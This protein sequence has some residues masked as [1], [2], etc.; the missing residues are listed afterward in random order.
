MDKLNR[1]TLYFLN[2]QLERAS[3]I[4]AILLDTKLNPDIEQLNQNTYLK[5]VDA[6]YIVQ[7]V[8]SAVNDVWK[9]ENTM[10]NIYVRRSN[11]N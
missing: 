10:P 4:L 8:Y 1:I 9:S 5:F 11:E 7:N 3:S 6:M 2:K